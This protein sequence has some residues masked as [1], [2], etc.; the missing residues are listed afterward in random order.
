MWT[1]SAFATTLRDRF[2]KPEYLYRFLRGRGSSLVREIGLD[3]ALFRLPWNIEIIADPAEALGK[4]L[5]RLAVYDLGV[6][7]TLWRLTKSGD[8]TVDVGANFGYMTS[9]MAVRSGS[10]GR[11]FAFEPHPRLYGLLCENLLLW[12]EK[13]ISSLMASV[14]ARQ[15]AVSDH[16]GDAHLRVPEDFASNKGLAFIAD[17]PLP[18]DLP[19]NCVRLDSAFAAEQNIDLMKVDV[20]GHELSVF[21]GAE[22]LLSEGR[23]RHIVFEEHGGFPTTVTAFLKQFG[24]T[25]FEIGVSLFGPILGGEANINFTP[26]RRWEPRSL[27]ATLDPA[28]VDATFSGR[29]WR[30]LSA[31]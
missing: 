24:Y 18:S 10:N 25:F 12:K 3:K 30:S 31:E 26:R 5:T 8:V 6:S 22:Q 11:I 17:A 20:E 23:I 4:A 27:L 21:R 13:Y 9:I 1:D 7:E 2:V 29:G 19:V 14:D 28:G 16:D 15:L